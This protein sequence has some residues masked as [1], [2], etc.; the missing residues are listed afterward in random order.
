MPIRITGMNSGLDTDSIIQALM[1]AYRVKGDK[2]KKEQTK[3]SWK[4]DKWK[5]LNSKVYSLYKSLDSL[6]FSTGYNLKKV[7]VSDSSKATVSGASNAVNGTRTMKI[8]Q[9]AQAAYLTGD[10]ISAENGKTTLS[11]LISTADGTPYGGGTIRI[12]G[13]GKTK[14]IEVT[15]DT[16]V[17]D[18]IKQLN[19]SGTGVSASYDNANKRIY[20]SS[21]K[22]GAAAGFELTA[23]DE[24][25]NKA[26]TA[27][28]LNS[29]VTISKAEGDAWNK[30]F[31][32]SDTNIEQKLKDAIDHIIEQKE[33]LEENKSLRDEELL[34][35]K[36]NKDTVKYLEA[37]KSLVQAKEDV[38]GDEE[39]ASAMAQLLK[40][41]E[42]NRAKEY[43]MD[44]KGKLR[45]KKTDGSDD[46]KAV[47][48]LETKKYKLD[49]DGNRVDITADNPVQDGDKTGVTYTFKKSDPSDSI[50]NLTKEYNILDKYDE[51]DE[52]TATPAQKAEKEE[53][54]SFDNLKKYA[55]NESAAKK[56]EKAADSAVEAGDYG[57][58]NVVERI[59]ANLE[60]TDAITKLEDELTDYN[61][62]LEQNSQELKN[63]NDAI[64]AL[65]EDLEKP[66]YAILD[67]NEID[68]DVEPD[69][70]DDYVNQLVQ[71]WIP[72]VK[73]HHDELNASKLVD[74]KGN[75]VT[76]SDDVDGNKLD[77]DG[78]LVGK[79]GNVYSQ[80]DYRFDASGNVVDMSGN[81]VD[82]NKALYQLF[83][84][85]EG[86]NPGAKMVQGTDAEI[87]LN[88]V[89]Y[90]SSSNSFNINGLSIQA[91]AKTNGD[92]IT[93]TTATD[94]QGIYDKIKDFISEYNSL[95]NEISSLYNAESAKG[96]EPLTS[97]EKEA[98]SD[99]EVEEWEAKVKGA[100]LRRDD[101][102]SSLMNSMTSSMLSSVKVGDKSYSL[103]SLG[104]KTAGYFNMTAATRNELHID[105]DEDDDTT[106]SKTNTLMNMLN[107][108]PDKVI[109]IIKGVTGNLYN[110][111]NKKMMSSNRLKSI[112]SIYNDKEM[113]QSYSD[114]T[115]TISAWE[116]KIQ[117][118]EDNYYKKFSAMEVALSKLQSQQSSLA[119]LLGQ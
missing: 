110:S 62:R 46:D 28:G 86:T 6:R 84:K 93:V 90:T 44:D 113:S 80:K 115:K 18:F 21:K 71:K 117:K 64:E 2:Y 58:Y 55:T 11:D 10:K 108:D 14:D 15:G 119:G 42:K 111:I 96:Y 95:I 52:S 88:G 82:K 105:G 31:D 25:G 104:I 16:T 27:L 85:K 69:K 114:Y 97:E 23:T 39:D 53:K 72:K 100:L 1:S 67:I 33:K 61:G 74:D 83:Y 92:E 112:N 76:L 3:I 51:Y 12:S 32:S 37:K 22:T 66:E 63:Y 40:M 89:S 29:D 87:E 5:A 41:S 102:L 59:N 20:I 73:Y 26:L 65:N 48:T 98:M 116:E 101:S 68:I 54:D 57:K 13:N 9:L 24:A 56:F 50:K 109:D 19:D 45:V 38:G 70:K 106:S 47:Y 94:T 103:A 81:L 79:D 77:K 78:N 35:Q 107:S 43:V 49:A 118:I 75:E 4:Q 30:Y 7:T 8:N 99:K 17:N 60:G 34:D 36:F 91:Q